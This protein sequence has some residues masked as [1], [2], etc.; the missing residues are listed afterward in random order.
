MTRVLITLVDEMINIVEK[1]D[2]EMKNHNTS[3]KNISLF[4]FTRRV[5]CPVGCR[6]L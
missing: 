3:L 1:H 6:I 2:E 5:D 4:F